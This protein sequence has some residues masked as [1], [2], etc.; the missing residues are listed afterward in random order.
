[1]FWYFSLDVG[2]PVARLDAAFSEGDGPIFLDY[3]EC[4]GD[5]ADLLDCRRNSPLG[6]VE[7]SHSSDVGIICPGKGFL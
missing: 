4:D 1:M 3:L 5:E 6:I 7:C 2:L